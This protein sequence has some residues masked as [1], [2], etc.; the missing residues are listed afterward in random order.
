MHAVFYKTAL[1]LDTVMEGTLVI[2]FYLMIMIFHVIICEKCVDES[3]K[4]VH[5]VEKALTWRTNMHF[6]NTV[7]VFLASKALKRT[8]IMVYNLF[9]I[10]YET[11]F[12]V[13]SEL[14]NSLSS[15]ITLSF[16]FCLTILSNV[17][18]LVQFDLTAAEES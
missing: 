12:G 7:E 6:R 18:V 8:P 10:T 13:R 17:I 5:L 4:T 11:I 1:T 14:L 9:P 16:Q 2:P 3:M 15:C